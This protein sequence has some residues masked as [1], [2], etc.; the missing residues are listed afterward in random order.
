MIENK[1]GQLSD[2]NVRELFQ[3]V[4]TEEK[5]QGGL[6]KNRFAMAFIGNDVNLVTAKLDLFNHWVKRFWT[7]SEDRLK[8][9]T[10]KEID[11]Y[12]LTFL[13]H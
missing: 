5:P 12:M 7:E 3:V 2:G 8:A 11:P 9:L 10:L 4:N 13:T 1:I 6:T